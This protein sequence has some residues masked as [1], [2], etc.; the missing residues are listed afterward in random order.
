MRQKIIDM[1]FHVGLVG[2]K[3]PQY[4]QMSSWYKDQLV[5]KI[6]LLF[7]GIKPEEVC[8]Q[9]LMDKTL[10]T[11]D[12]S[13]VDQVVCLALDPV[14]D[15]D[16]N[17]RKDWTHMWVDNSYILKLQQKLSSK[18]LFGASVHPYDKNFQK[19]V[20][21]C[22]DQGAVLL[23]WLP[24][25]QQINLADHRVGEAM[26]FLTTAKHGKPL[27][28]LLHVGPE[29][30]IETSNPPTKSFD[31]LSWGAMDKVWNWFRGKHK[32]HT[33]DIKGIHQNIHFGLDNGMIIIF[34]H[35]GLP[36]F[37]SGFLKSILEHS[38][39]KIVSQ[40]LQ[41]NEQ[42]TYT[43]RCYSDV[44][45]FCTPFRQK[46]FS[47]VRKL[48]KDSI[49]YGSDFPTPAFE[50]SSNLDEAR[51]DFEAVMQG[52]FDRLIIPQDNLLDVNYRELSNA[53]SGH[54]MFNNF[55]KLMS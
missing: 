46:Y 10:D 38:D 54:P 28:L 23:K 2:D 11:I 8:D 18:I 15:T 30:A 44:S 3:Y 41:E 45:A 22:V 32:W 42:N 9:V 31:Y 55:K 50:L 49:L 39:F 37:A 52:R 43:G 13:F 14:F 24:S 20:A 34:A 7:A 17:E 1:H 26:E 51:K 40:Y 21:K 35:C 6:F 33:P 53:F 36:Y 16:G 48:P 5:F 27:P 12:R 19:R 47:D 25:A 29:Y 4:G